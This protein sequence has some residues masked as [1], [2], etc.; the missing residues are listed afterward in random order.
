MQIIDILSFNHF[1]IYFLIGLKFK[2][3]YKLIFILSILWEIFEYTI[4]YIDYTREF[5][6][7]YWMVDQYYWNEKNIVNKLFDV[8]FNMLGY[9]IGNQFML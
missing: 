6:I 5:M 3:Y 7:K 1:M 2:N 8:I 9:F 4:S